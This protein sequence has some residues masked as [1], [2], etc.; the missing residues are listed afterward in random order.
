MVPYRCKL[1][2]WFDFRDPICLIDYGDVEHGLCRK[3]WPI[4]H[5]DKAGHYHSSWVFV[6]PED[7]CGEWMPD[8]G[9]A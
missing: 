3:K 8:K 2:Q 1:C 4:V 9:G 7:F 6:K 5:L